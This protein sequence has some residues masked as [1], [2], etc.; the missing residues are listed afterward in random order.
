[1]RV[2]DWYLL[3][4]A[5]VGLLPVH[6]Q[7]VER[8]E[9]LTF[10]SM[11]EAP[12]RNQNLWSVEAVIDALP[13]E[14]LRNFGLMYGSNDSNQY[15]SPSFP[16]VIVVGDPGAFQHPS[17]LLMAFS[18]HPDQ[19][20]Y[21]NLEA[22][23][24]DPVDNQYIFYQVQ[25]DPASSRRPEIRVNPQE[26]TKC[27]L[28]NNTLGQRPIWPSMNIA[29]LWPLVYGSDR[30]NLPA[31]EIEAEMYRQFMRGQA[32]G[33]RYKLLPKI[34]Q[35]LAFEFRD[36]P[37]DLSE[38]IKHRRYS[39]ESTARDNQ[40][41][42]LFPPERRGPGHTLSARNF[43]FDEY[44]GHVIGVYAANNLIQVPGF[45]RIRAA[46]LAALLQAKFTGAFAWDVLKE[47]NQVSPLSFQHSETVRRSKKVHEE[48]AATA[49]VK[50][51]LLA[52][53]LRVESS[54]L[55]SFEIYKHRNWELM[56]LALVHLHLENLSSTHI[57][58]Q[59]SLGRSG[60]K[61]D[62][63]NGLNWR[64]SIAAF[65][66]TLLASVLRD[67]PYLKK[68]FDLESS[69]S[70]GLYTKWS[71]RDSAPDHWSTFFKELHDVDI[72]HSCEDNLLL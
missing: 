18:G 4:A 3:S 64:G 11:V 69:Y 42:Q 46:V 36:L 72:R 37:H 62:Y 71:M 44:F 10:R 22:I 61:H 17:Y 19:K 49:S 23:D 58:D 1:M 13:D 15:A 26:C 51:K 63:A 70:Q 27:H 65:F 59:L 14:Y 54:S 12:I 40:L 7:A 56:A 47:V 31:M 5:F 53:A 33:G 43:R 6:V 35:T 21:W 50:S 57:L 25:F 48:M 41:E 34:D 52:N 8:G 30:R 16:R 28:H 55:S 68:H 29:P 20:G 9:V 24:Y 45:R 60:E 67:H 32:K 2:L 39:D 38:G 66:N